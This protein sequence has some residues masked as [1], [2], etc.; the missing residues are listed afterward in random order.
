MPH[1]ALGNLVRGVDGV[2]G[3]HLAAVNDDPGCRVGGGHRTS[4][5]FSSCV[6]KHSEW[7]CVGPQDVSLTTAVRSGVL[8]CSLS[9]PR[10]P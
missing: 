5:Q 9:L 1:Q 8:S 10:C 3:G 6:G 2:W 4:L 7:G